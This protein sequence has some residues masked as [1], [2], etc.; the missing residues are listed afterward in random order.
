[1]KYTK[2]CNTENKD[3]EVRERQKENEYFVK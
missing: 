3:W 2:D 1:M